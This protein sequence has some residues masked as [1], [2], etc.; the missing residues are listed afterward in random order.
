MGLDS[1]KSLSSLF[2][3][4]SWRS[5]VS[6]LAVPLT[7]LLYPLF[8]LAARAEVRV[9][10]CSGT[11][12]QLTVQEQGNTRTDRFRFL[13]RLEAEASNA[14]AALVQ[15][16]GRLDR[17]RTELRPL[18]QGDLEVPA[19]STFPISRS[20]FP[21]RFRASTTIRGSV[22]RSQYDTLIQLAGQLP[23][24]R[25]QGM[26]SLASLQGQTE[27]E[28]RLLKRALKRGQLQ[29]ASTASALGLSRVKLL[30]IDQRSQPASP[31]LATAVT[32]APRFR[33]GEAPLPTVSLSLTLDYCL[34]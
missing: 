18:V 16:N 22:S 3:M 14:A 31:G 29:A 12:L 8:S 30:R 26:T 28:E 4:S 24:V 6:L 9:P 5:T 21:D 2:V 23:G 27:L 33:P 15:L 20:Q 17:L 1:T 7:V 19:P 11:V 13:L 34:S 25:L 10:R 32:A